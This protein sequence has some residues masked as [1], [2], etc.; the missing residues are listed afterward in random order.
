[1]E[2][3][4]LQ[5]ERHSTERTT[6]PSGKSRQAS[7]SNRISPGRQPLTS[8]SSSRLHVLQ[9][10]SS[11][12][13]GAALLIGGGAVFYSQNKSLPFG[14]GQG[15]G[16]QSKIAGSVTETPRPELIFH[17]QVSRL[18]DFRASSGG[19]PTFPA[20]SGQWISDTFP[21]TV[22]GAAALRKPPDAFPIILPNC[23]N[24]PNSNAPQQSRLSSR[25]SR[26]FGKRKLGRLQK[27]GN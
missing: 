26:R 16:G 6:S 1:M 5:L 25:S 2:Q 7:A 18:A 12:R 8:S 20:K 9:I 3:P 11:T 24:Q 27:Q 19:I 4:R 17:W 21:V 10:K 22:A 15:Q 23:R 13:S 14:S